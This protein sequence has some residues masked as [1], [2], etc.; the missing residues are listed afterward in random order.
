VSDDRRRAKSYF[1]ELAPEYDRAFRLAGRDP[2]SALVNRF[3]R[4]RTF[5]RRMRLLESLFGELGLSGKSVLDLGCGSGQV[6][7]LAAKMGAQ[8]HAVDIAPRMLEIARQGAQSAGVQERVSFEEGDVASRTYP[9]ADVVLLVGVIEYY[10]DF[11]SVVRRAAEAAR[12]TLI[13]AHTSRVAY[14]MLLRRLLF[15]VR[16]AS[17][18]FHKMDDVVRA[19]EAA[20]LALSR[21]IDEHAFSILLFEREPRG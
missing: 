9:P 2:L 16:G 15:A 13:V 12:G 1:D 6:S 10:A 8:V 5:V 21:R 18:Y 19:A 4:G 17:L 20:G 7:A 3:F 14:R 11:A